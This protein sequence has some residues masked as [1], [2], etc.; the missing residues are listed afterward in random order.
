MIKE[1]RK[2][3]WELKELKDKRTR[4][5]LGGIEATQEDYDRICKHIEKLENN[6]ILK[7]FIKKEVN[8]PVLIL[9]YDSFEDDELFIC[10]FKIE[11]PD[12]I[13]DLDK[14]I[15]EVKKWVDAKLPSTKEK[16]AMNKKE[17]VITLTIK[18][19]GQDGRCRWCSSFR[20]ALEEFL[21][22]KKLAGITQNK[23][24]V[25]EKGWN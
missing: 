1:I 6:P 17:N 3:S 9:K 18:G 19:K 22:E 13:N 5:E 12:N 20:T 2:L 16:C 14:K 25:F 10:Q 11:L 23:T 7:S 15:F 21:S 4:M 8:L 24:C